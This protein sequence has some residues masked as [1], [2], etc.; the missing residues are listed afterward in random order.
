MNSNV[1]QFN[2]IDLKFEQNFVFNTLDGEKL[3]FNVKLDNKGISEITNLFADLTKN[4]GENAE[5]KYIEVLEIS[6]KLM[7]GT[8]QNKIF[9]EKID[10]INRIAI[11]QKLFDLIKE[12]TPDILKKN[13]N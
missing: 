9:K 7:L 4:G 1:L 2:E 11:L 13:L 3:E 5:L 6:S 12:N 8:K 10:L